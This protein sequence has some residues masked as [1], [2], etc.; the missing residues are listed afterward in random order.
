V[1]E[2]MRDRPDRREV[3]QILCSASVW[4][5]YH[6]GFARADPFA[7]VPQGV[8]SIVTNSLAANPASLN[9]DWFGTTLLLGLL[10]WYRRGIADVRPFSTAWLDYHLSSGALSRYSGAKSREAVAGGIHITTYAGHYGLAFPCYEMAVQ[11]GDERA[12]RVCIDVGKIILHQASRNR[13][14]MV[15]HDDS[16][17]F[18]IP[19]TCY[20][21]VRALMSASALDTRCGIVFKEQADYQLRTYIDA[22]LSP[23]TG[24]A[25][26][27]LFRQGPGKTFW[28]RASGWLMWAINSMLRLLPPTDPAFDKYLRDLESLAT[29]MGRTQDSSGGF[30]V[31]LDDPGTP[32]ETTG[33]AM[34]ASGVHE[35]VR[36]K[37]LPASHAAAADRAWEFVKG[38]I[39]DGG[40]IRNAYTGWAIPAEQHV[41]S[42]DEHKMG[43]IPGFIL[44]VGNEITLK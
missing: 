6:A 37:W 4:G 29:G 27:V 15:E 20:F 10:E 11:F 8:R 17:E 3:L 40:D 19:D 14:G 22:F 16:G 2:K 26:T 28:T 42:M 1:E 24:L 36:R 31:L 39:S 5:T 13:L 18:A 7:E 38:N 25:R 44:I 21:V 34:F 9:T 23:E 35:A 32:L 33:T 43:W 12:R 30:R 41:S